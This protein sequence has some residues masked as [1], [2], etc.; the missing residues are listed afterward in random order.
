MTLQQDG[1]PSTH[2]GPLP[3]T[4][5]PG[6]AAPT[7]RRRTPVL[8]AGTVGAVLVAGTAGFFVGRASVDTTDDG[9][10]S[11]LQAA[12][13]DTRLEAAFQ[14]C[15]SRDTDDTLSLADAGRTIVADTRSEYGDVAGVA[16]VLGEL[17]TPESIT[18]QISRTTAMMGV[19]DGDHDGLHYSWSYHPDNGMNLVIS[20]DG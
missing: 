8:I 7:T 3:A 14:D 19:Q 5:Q 9:G 18:A 13:E 2:P 20:A 15:L 12:A 6:T 16:C 1:V 11:G 17:G 4:A 10:P